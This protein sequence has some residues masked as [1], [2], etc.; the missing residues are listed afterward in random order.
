[1]CRCQDEI[2]SCMNACLF[3]HGHIGRVCQPLIPPAID[4]WYAPPRRANTTMNIVIDT[5]CYV[6]IIRVHDRA[7]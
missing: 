1:M 3:V 6:Y 2:A 7:Y 5:P 4:K